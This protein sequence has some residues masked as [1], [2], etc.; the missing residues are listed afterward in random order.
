MAETKIETSWYG[1]IAVFASIACAVECAFRPLAILLLP[2]LGLQLV[3]GEW[4][5][6]AL[7]GSVLVLGG[8]R[9]A[10]RLFWGRT[11]S[12]PLS[13]FATGFLAIAAGHFFADGTALGISLTVCGALIAAAAQLMER[14]VP[15]DCCEFHRT[16]DDDACD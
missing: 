1:R 9:I 8:G 16:M 12:R 14:S 3:T 13:I 2:L 10:V 11:S 6:L 4:F 5:E 15:R 7:L